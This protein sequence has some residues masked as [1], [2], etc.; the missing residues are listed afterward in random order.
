MAVLAGIDEAGYGP[1]LGPLVSALTVFSVPKA[2]SDKS[3]WNVLAASIALHPARSSGRLAV[4]DSKKLFT[5]RDGLVRLERC[6]LT[7]MHLL[8][9]PADHLSELLRSLGADCQQQMNNYPWYEGQSVRLPLAA[10]PMDLA[11]CLNALRLDTQRNGIAFLAARSQVLLV[12]R[13]NDL[14]EKTRNKSAVLFGLVGKYMV[15][16][17]KAYVGEGL[18]IHVDKL[19]GR[20]RYRSHLQQL[21]GGWDLRI[22]QET[23][24][25]SSY[26]LS[27]NSLSWQ[28]HFEAK[29]ESSHLPVALASIYAKYVRELFMELLNRYWRREVSGLRP[30]AGYYSDGRRFLA[31]IGEHCKRLKTPMRRL[32]RIR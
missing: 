8:A 14:A 29:A 7:F 9:Q 19:G 5:R 18:V 4:A 25:S 32:L 10:D 31:D 12:G 20:S 6:A 1:L 26:Q 21:F 15:R 13:Y 11:T 27:K 17:V 22:L 3:L 28:V 30:T 24:Q 2:L 23:R 16:L